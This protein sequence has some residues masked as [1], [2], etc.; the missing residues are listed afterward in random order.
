[1]E[2]EMV[3]A[4]GLSDLLRQAP[5]GCVLYWAR[6]L[7]VG[8]EVRGKEEQSP[9]RR[10]EVADV[11]ERLD[12]HDL[13]IENPQADFA[14]G[15]VVSI[16]GHAV[17]DSPVK[18]HPRVILNHNTGKWFPVYPLPDQGGWDMTWW[19]HKNW[20]AYTGKPDIFNGG[21]GGVLARGNPNKTGHQKARE[22]VTPQMMLFSILIVPACIA[23]PILAVVLLVKA[24]GL[25]FLLL[26]AGVAFLIWRKRKTPAKVNLAP[27]YQEMVNRAQTFALN[28]PDPEHSWEANPR[29]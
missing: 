4:A 6:G 17:A 24:P 15:D 9:F 1:M 13:C 29:Y 20:L 16:F 8:S 27:I 2:T 19:Q 21:P 14:Q 28:N 11:D 5:P 18:P 12:T 10:V 7:V 26:V 3:N 25:F 22:G 23:A